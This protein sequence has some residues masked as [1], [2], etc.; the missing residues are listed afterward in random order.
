M[1]RHLVTSTF[2]TSILPLPSSEKDAE[3]PASW[4][5]RFLLVEKNLKTPTQR[6]ALMS[7]TRLEQR[8][9]EGS[10]WEAYLKTCE[11]YNVSSALP[12]L[13]ITSVPT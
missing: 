6:A 10:M 2:L 12:R 7:L 1:Q 5:D 9:G 3:D 8:T 13:C 4:T 11:R